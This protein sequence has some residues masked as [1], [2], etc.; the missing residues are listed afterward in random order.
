MFPSPTLFVLPLAVAIT[1]SPDES[2]LIGSP[3]ESFESGL[4]ELVTA[5]NPWTVASF[6]SVRLVGGDE[7]L[8]ES[9]ARGN[10]QRDGDDPRQTPGVPACDLIS[11]LMKGESEG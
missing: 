9:D 11:A 5:S 2:C 8:L 1:P 6:G 7:A 4:D 3:E 10:H